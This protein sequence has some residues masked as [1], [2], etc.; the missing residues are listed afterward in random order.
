MKRATRL[1][2]VA[3]EGRIPAIRGMPVL[4]EEDAE[5]IVRAIMAMRGA[6][7]KKH[8]EARRGGNLKLPMKR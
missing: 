4:D 5:M 6:D 7:K 2:A 1:K 3:V 8:E